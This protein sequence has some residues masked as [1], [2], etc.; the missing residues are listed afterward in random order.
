MLSIQEINLY[1]EQYKE[2]KLIHFAFQ[3]SEFIFRSLT[4]EEFKLI[5]SY[6]ENRKE[7]E[8]KI[9]SLSCVYP[10]DYDFSQG[11]A[12]IPEIIASKIEKISDIQD[13]KDPILYYKKEMENVSFQ[14]TCMDFVKAFIPEYTYEEMS[15]WTWAKLMKFVARAERIAK[16]KGFDYSLQD[17]TETYNQEIDKMSLDNQSYIDGLYK[18]GIDPMFYFKDEIEEEIRSKNKIIDYPIISDGK[19]YDDE[20]INAIRRQ[21]AIT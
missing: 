6:P 18:S 11:Y 20:V 21:R 1:K 2:Y 13:F 4:I 8:D 16:L 7:I 3:D 9:C 17:N 15:T 12:G 14:D 19:W 10:E 5:Y